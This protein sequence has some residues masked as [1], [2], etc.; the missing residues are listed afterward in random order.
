MRPPDSAAVA[1][2]RLPTTS[3]IATTTVE[4]ESE[5]RAPY[6]IRAS[7]SRPSASQPNGCARL[8]PA[9]MFA[10][11]IERGSARNSIG[12]TIAADNDRD[13]NSHSNSQ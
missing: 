6:S 9:R 1:P 5:S 13:D 4:I 10:R 3:E 11:S 7:M 8:G 2:I 12:P